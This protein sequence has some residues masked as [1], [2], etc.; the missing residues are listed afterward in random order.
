M[1]E[2]PQ[3]QTFFALTDGTG[4]T[5]S[6]PMTI[7]EDDFTDV[8]RK[9]VTGHNLTPAKT[10]ALSGLDENTLLKFLQG[11]FC[12][13]SARQL[14]PLLG[15]N[16]EAFARHPDYQP[17]PLTL[18]GIT[19]LKLPFEN[20]WVNAWLVCDENTLLLFD[21]GYL[22]PNLLLAIDAAHGRLPDQT[23]IT[24]AHRDH[25]G[26]LAYLLAMGIP[27]H[28]A[29]IPNTIPIT[30]GYS[31]THGRLTLRA[32][33]L[34]GHASPALGF[35][36]DGLAQP[37]LVTGDALFAGSIGGCASP[38]TYQHALHRL[39]QVLSPLPD[40]TVLLPGHGPATTLGE[41][42]AANPFL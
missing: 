24:H 28:A 12:E 26:A 11:T 30:P 35:H 8:L 4:C 39:Y 21:A 10:A 2:N 42:R 15:L 37:L 17:H 33:D 1:R 22:T 18:P 31:V 23:F 9:A 38:A 40:T 36:L 25:I 5:D 16:I 14:A 27:V 20:E 6:C 34:S 41:E 29:G 3:R 19:R 13:K 32:C 7:L